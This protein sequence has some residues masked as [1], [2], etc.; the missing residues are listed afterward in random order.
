MAEAE[1]RTRGEFVHALLSSDA[2]AASLLRRARAIGIDLHAVTTVAVVDARPVGATAAAAF[3]ARLAAELRGW[4][5]AHAGRVV[6]L[7]PTDVDRAR[8][9]VARLATHDTASPTTGLASGEGGPEGVRSAH[10]EARQTAALLLALDRAGTCATSDELG[11][12]R[13]LFS[14]SGRAGLATF[15]PRRSARCTTTTRSTSATSPR[16]WRPTSSRRGTTPAP[17][18]SSTSTPTRSTSGST[19]SPRSSGPGGRSPIAPSSCRWRCACTACWPPARAERRRAGCGDA[20][21]ATD[22]G[23]PHVRSISARARRRTSPWPRPPPGHTVDELPPDPGAHGMPTFRTTDDVTLAYTDQGEG[24][25]V[26]LVHGYTA[27]ASSWVLTVDAL[28]AAGHRAIAFDRRAHGESDTPAHG[29]R[30]ARHGRDLGELLAHLDLDDAVVVGA[31]MGGNTIWAYVDQFGPARLA[32]AVI[33]DQTPKMLNAAGWEHGFYGYDADNAGTLFAHGV[34]D[35]GW[36]RTVDRSA[37]RCSESSSASAHHRRSAT[38]R[39]PRPSRSWPTTHC[40][41]GATSCG[42]SRCHC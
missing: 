2:D 29:Q 12:Y 38:P 26:V 41:T 4:S 36:G 7:L 21:V 42:A 19:G 9:A 27:P 32:A 15:M 14:S 18:R 37:A 34:P 16:P 3:A 31:S 10:E 20:G 1:L 6:V 30:M 23:P 24:R 17:A 11:L 39:P 33:V 28:L 35:N 40:R 13:S 22:A 25:P 5:A 8:A